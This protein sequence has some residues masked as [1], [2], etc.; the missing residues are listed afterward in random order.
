MNALI[1][2][3]TT[4]E[5]SIQEVFSNLKKGDD[6]FKGFKFDISDNIELLQKLLT[7]ETKAGDTPGD[8]IR[9]SHLI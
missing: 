2:G 8:F 1:N 4:M 9:R 5:M 6:Y 7:K 3:L